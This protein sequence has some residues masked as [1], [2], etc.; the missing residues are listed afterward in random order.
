MHDFFLCTKVPRTSHLI[1]VDQAGNESLLN[2]ITRYYVSN[3]GGSL[4]KCMPPL[5]RKASKEWRRIGIKVGHLVYP[6]N[7][8]IHATARINYEYYIIEA[9]KLT[10][11]STN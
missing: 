2:N 6:C 9:E 11:R 1:L 10:L 3:E 4:I 8:I 5:A 7:K